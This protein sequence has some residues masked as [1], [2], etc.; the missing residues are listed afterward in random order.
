MT[1]PNTGIEGGNAG[2][3]VRPTDFADP[4]H[5][6]IEG[7]GRRCGAWGRGGGGV[8]EGPS[9]PITPFH[10]SDGPISVR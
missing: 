9:S 5:W 6:S 1:S 8:L 3:N 4:K 7:L 2:H 10:N